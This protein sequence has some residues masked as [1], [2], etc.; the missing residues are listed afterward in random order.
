MTVTQDAVTAIKARLDATT[1]PW[2]TVDVLDGSPA[3]NNTPTG[4]YICIYDQTGQ[5]VRRKYLGQPSGLYW[6]VQLSC[7]ARTAAGL[8]DLVRIVRGTVLNWPPIDGAT[9]V[10]EDGSNPTLTTG[11]GN[12]M[13][14]TAPLTLHCY[15]PAEET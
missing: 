7:T 3:V 12:D 10:V 2:P 9:P 5:T 4:P 6:P 8:R 11:T 14:I 15:L 1:W 13:R